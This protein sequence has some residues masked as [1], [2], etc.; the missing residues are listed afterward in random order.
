MAYEACNG[1]RIRTM[2]LKENEDG[3]ATVVETLRTEGKAY[4]WEFSLSSENE[5]RFLNESNTSDFYGVYPKHVQVWV[6]DMTQYT[7]V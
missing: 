3:T 5:L 7:A 2:Y 6:N 4:H 1:G